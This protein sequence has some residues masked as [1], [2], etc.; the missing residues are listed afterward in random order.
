MFSVGTLNIHCGR[1]HAGVPFPVSAAV[2]ALDTDVVV[3]QETWRADGT[4]SVARQAAT[5]SGYPHCVELDFVGRTHLRELRVVADDRAD[6]P[7][8]TGLAVLSRLPV[9]G[10]GQLC[11]GSAPGDKV[12]RTAQVVEVAVG[13]VVVRI[14]NVHL[15]YRLPFGPGQVRRLVRALRGTGAPTVIAGDLNM[16]RPTVYLARPYRPAVR[17]RT[18]PARLPVAQL[19]HVLVDDGFE[20]VDGGVVRAVGS[21][22]LP[23]RADLTVHCR[24]LPDC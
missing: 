9:R 6:E 19:D 10:Q 1:D 12:A 13:D 2:A 15:T 18:W 21:D 5:E 17:A 7:G 23:L 14:V 24:H 20:V 4:V 22:H 3:V 16:C 11:L 8:T